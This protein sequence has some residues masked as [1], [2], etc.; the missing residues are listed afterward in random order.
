MIAFWTNAMGRASFERF[1]RLNTDE[2]YPAFDLV[3]YEDL[4]PRQPL[5]AK[6][7]IFAAL[8]QLDP[9]GMPAVEAL[10]DR[11]AAV[12]GVRRLNDPRRVLHRYELLT[13]LADQGLNRFR[14]WRSTDDLS[15]VRYP[16]FVR[17]ERR[18][19]G[20]R[21]LLRDRRALDRALR[22][23]A[24]RGFKRRDLLVV[25]FCETADR[26]GLYRKYGALKVGEAI[27]PRH[28]MI[29]RGWMLKSP[30]RIATVEGAREELAYVRDNPHEAWLR[31]VFRIAGI[32]YGRVDYGVL[33]GAPQIWE[34]NLDPMLG[35]VRG[36]DR[37]PPDLAAVLAERR[38]IAACRLR[39]A[40]LAL[41]AGDSP[42]PVTADVPVEALAAIRRRTRSVRWRKRV[43][44]VARWCQRQPVLGPPIRW[45]S[46]RTAR[47]RVP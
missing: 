10:W 45:V 4:E 21:H 15:R 20:A 23:L 33:D 7:H 11:L 16:A 47:F 25:E 22:G 14:V 29:G 2:T 37:P 27:L 43:R 28:M 39:D 12:P 13:A 31:E 1:L 24:A 8:D 34:I 19:T 18:H 42:R 36:P 17:E 26:D 32:D 9:R 5:A 40:F 35:T 38:S 3:R 41:Q 46:A 6:A 44:S 30:S